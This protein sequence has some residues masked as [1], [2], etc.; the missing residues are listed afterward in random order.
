METNITQ[1]KKEGYCK[2]ES[3]MSLDEIDDLNEIVENCNFSKDHVFLESDDKTVKR[4]LKLEEYHDCFE[5]LITK[6]KPVADAFLSED[7]KFLGMHLICK[8]PNITGP[9][10]AHQDN[11]YFKINSEKGITFWM[12]LCDTD[13]KN[14]GMYY[15]IKSPNKTIDHQIYSRQVSFLQNIPIKPL[16]IDAHNESTDILIKTKKGDCLVHNMITIH[17]TCEN[18]SANVRKVVSVYFSV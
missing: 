16:Y 14:G 13:D 12:P 6:L 5:K 1:F 9:I 2:V 15:A 11:A 10:K 18:N 7:S 8:H 4:V 17:R 3:L